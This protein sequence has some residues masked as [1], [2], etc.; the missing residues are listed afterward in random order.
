[1]RWGKTWFIKL[2]LCSSWQT[3][4]IRWKNIYTVYYATQKVLIWWNDPSIAKFYSVISQIVSIIDQNESV[5]VPVDNQFLDFIYIAVRCNFLD[6]C[7]FFTGCCVVWKAIRHVL[8]FL[9]AAKY[10]VTQYFGR[11]FF[12]L[13]Y[14]QTAMARY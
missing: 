13:L 3:V 12:L 8:Y 9:L 10:V 6:I 5:N 7:L 4:K 1:M 11:G 14:C 2:N